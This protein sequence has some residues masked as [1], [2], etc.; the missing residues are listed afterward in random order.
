[1][2]TE[3][4]QRRIRIEFDKCQRAVRRVKVSENSQRKVRIISVKI[5]SHKS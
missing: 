5:L 2:V 1:M 3:N 4:G